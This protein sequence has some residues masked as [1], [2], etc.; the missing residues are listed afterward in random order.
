MKILIHGRKNGYTILYPKPTPT[1]FYSFASDIQSISAN[2]YDVY[3]GKNFYTLAFVDGGCVFTIYVIGDDVER[4]QLGE[5]GISVFIPNTQKLSGVDVKNLLDELIN[6][7]N[8]NYIFYNK[9][10]E[11]K[12]GFD[13]FLFTSLAESYDAKLITQP[14]NSD[15]VTTGTQDPAFHYYE[16][17]SKLIEYFDKPFQEEYSDYKQILFIDSNLQGA[18]NPLNVLR[19]SGVEVNPDLT[20]ENYYLNNYNRSKGVTITANGKSRS[21][22]KGENQIRAKWQVEIKYSKDY[23]KPIEATGSISN[24]SS[25]I[26]KYLEINGKDIIIKYDAFLPE[27]ETKTITFDVVTKKDGVKVTD[28]EIQVDTQTWQ[29]RSDVTFAAEELGK[30]H[31]I[32]ARKGEFLF[33]DVLR[34]TPKNYSPVSITLLLIEKRIVKITAT[35]Q[36]NGDSIWQ[37]KVR[38][39]GKDFY[40][41]T[42]QIEFVGDEIDKEWNIQIEKSREYFESE[43]KKFCPAT[44]GNEIIFKLK[45]AKMQPIEPDNPGGSEH[46]SNNK[47]KKPKSFAAKAKAFFSKSAVIASTIVVVLIIVLGILDFYDD[48]DNETP[49]TK[50][51]LTAQ[52][53]TVY[54]DGN[55]LSL[56]TLNEF[57][58]NWEKQ[59]PG[60]ITHSSIEWNNPTTWFV[61]SNEAKSDSNDYK[62]WNESSQLIDKAIDIRILINNKDFVELKKVL[63]YFNKQLSFKTAIEKIDSTKYIKIRKELD[64]IST[65]T[66]TQ[67]VDSVNVILTQKEPKKQE[68][69]QEQ[70]KGEK[71]T[72]QEKEKSAKTEHTKEQPKAQKRKNPAAPTQQETL[73]AEKTSEIIKYLK[74]SELKKVTLNKYLIDA[75][76]NTTLIASVNL[77]LKLWSLDGTR[78]KSYSSYQKELN[79]DSY[80]KNSELK[81][82]I[83]AM[84]DKEPPKYIKELP[85]IDQNKSLSQIKSKVQ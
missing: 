24:P 81:D 56:D 70:K 37:F 65:L 71:E 82:F 69:P 60:I 29:S 84:C 83:D 61:G 51:L 17:D 18:A 10:D 64:N 85:E 11:P 21:D 47:Q 3:Y 16:S 9:I 1:E 50:T 41:V 7:F 12:N 8:R 48:R 36:E 67:I 39:T 40:K 23:Y 49:S 62:K 28:A 77:C 15:N 27:P 34:I 5:I 31:K 14:I 42:D 4:G 33:S 6:T 22:K 78:N 52:R 55:S 68:Q 26:H 74:S 45:K 72:V 25:E 46:N 20:N 43:N 32:A 63:G 57:K 53:I 73:S 19:N 80:L 54:V 44:D 30:E 66:L 75:G 79:Q 35:D 38:I 58:V 59:K 76:K 13:W 2:N